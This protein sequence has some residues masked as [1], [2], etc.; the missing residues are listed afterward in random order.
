MREDRPRVLPETPRG[1]V[2]VGAVDQHDAEL[3]D[4]DGDHAH[5]RAEAVNPE[6]KGTKAAAPY[7]SLPALAG[8]DAALVGVL[9]AG[10]RALADMPKSRAIG[11]TNEGVFEIITDF[12]DF[13]GKVPVTVCNK[14]VL[15]SLVKAGAFDYITKPFELDKISHSVK[16]V[17]DY[18]DLTAEVARALAL[19]HVSGVLIRGIVKDG[20]AER[21]GIRAGDQIVSVD[22][23]PI[24]L[25]PA[26]RSGDLAVALED[27]VVERGPFRLGPLDFGVQWGERLSIAGPNGSG[28]T[29]LIDALLGR[30]EL[31]SGMRRVGPSVVFGEI[32][33]ERSLF[34]TDEPLIRTFCAESSLREDEART[35]LA[36]SGLT[37]TPAEDLTD[38][39]R[40]VVALARKGKA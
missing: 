33:Q 21:A 15:E 12:A 2:A 8:I 19:D 7:A 3:H 18:Q 35:L 5:G 14:R 4:V 1:L 40:K 37:I 9:D 24:D 6:Q 32:G 23:T 29:T 20:P 27:A 25:A 31:E 22:A 36:K 30:V 39:A 13:M 38:A 10:W 11:A 26:G 17:L 34:A 28:K 16:R